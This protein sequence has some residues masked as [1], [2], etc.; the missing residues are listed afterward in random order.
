MSEF[1]LMR[2][3]KKTLELTNELMKNITIPTEQTH[4]LSKKINFVKIQKK[5]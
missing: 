1:F 3:K 4:A 5:F 2:R